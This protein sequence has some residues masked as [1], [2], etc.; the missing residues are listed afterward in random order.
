MK[1]GFNQMFHF[2]PP[3]NVRK[4]LVIWRLQGK[5]KFKCEFYHKRNVIETQNFTMERK[6]LKVSYMPWK[7][8]SNLKKTLLKF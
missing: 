8:T 4:T 1:V 7:A 3:E 2:I 5:Y 6:V